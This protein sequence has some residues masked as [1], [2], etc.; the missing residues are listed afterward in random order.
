MTTGLNSL[1]QHGM[2]RYATF[3]EES[4]QIES[5]RIPLVEYQNALMYMDGGVED[6]D[7]RLP[8]YVEDHVKA[9][10]YVL[11][12]VDRVPNVH[13]VLEIHRRLM[14][15]SR[16]GPQNIGHF[17]RTAVMVGGELCPNPV[18]VPFMIDH[19]CWTLTQNPNPLDAH[20]KFEIIHPFVDGNGRTGRLLWLW[21]QLNQAQR[22][23]PFL[24]IAG[25][26][27]ETFEDK[28]QKY[29]ADL[30]NE[31]LTRVG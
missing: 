27:G 12:N 24:E 18:S 9:L 30:R 3:L 17:R 22:I 1:I 20:K 7:N 21:L 2:G 19:W 8:Q 11:A 13:D 23:G 10:A 31:R 29:Y 26:A 4:D 15:S 28:R 5:I 14:I 16:I 6:E 25:Y